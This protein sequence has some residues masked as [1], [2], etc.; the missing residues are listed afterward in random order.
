VGK[1]AILQTI[2]EGIPLSKRPVSIVPFYWPILAATIVTGCGGST[3]P[4]LPSTSA[5]SPQKSTDAALPASIASLVFANSVHPFDINRRGVEEERFTVSMFPKYQAPDYSFTT[6]PSDDCFQFFTPILLG[7]STI[8]MTYLPKYN[9]IHLDFCDFT[10]TNDVTN[11]SENVNIRF[12]TPVGTIEF[13]PQVVALNS[14]QELLG[15]T[16]TTIISQTNATQ[17]FALPSNPIACTDPTLAAKPQPNTTPTLETAT[18]TKEV[19]C[20]VFVSNATPIFG[21]GSTAG[22]TDEFVIRFPAQV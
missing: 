13:S 9:S 19:D 4:Q 18:F 10:V 5:N 11:I 1:S 17:P 14:P 8:Y 12:L 3:S 22:T 16:I 20:A 6:R 7:N 2:V 15:T 21:E